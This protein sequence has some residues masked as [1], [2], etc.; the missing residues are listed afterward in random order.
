MATG[1]TT[2][3]QF[4]VLRVASNKEDRVREALT[5]AGIDAPELDRMAASIT[6]PDGSPRFVWTDTRPDADIYARVILA[7]YEKACA[8][9]AA[10]VAR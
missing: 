5:S 9:S 2:G 8:R 7:C 4:F 6:L 3:M 10:T 1:T